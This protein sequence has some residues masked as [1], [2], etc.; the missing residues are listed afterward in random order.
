M[1]KIGAYVAAEVAA[2]IRNDAIVK[3]RNVITPRPAKEFADVAD[4]ILGLR[5]SSR[6]RR[7]VGTTWVDII[8]LKIDEDE[9]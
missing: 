7:G 1:R 9:R 8:V 3:H 5:M 2:G 4:E 6:P